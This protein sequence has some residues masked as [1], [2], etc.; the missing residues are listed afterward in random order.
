MEDILRIWLACQGDMKAVEF[1][2]LLET[3]GSAGK[4]VEGFQSYLSKG[5]DDEGDDEIFKGLRQKLSSAMD[6]RINDKLLIDFRNS[7]EKHGIKAITILNSDYPELL[8]EIQEPPPVLFIKGQW[9]LLGNTDAEGRIADSL[10]TDKDVL[11]V[12]MVG[13]RNGSEYGIKAANYLAEGLVKKGAIIVSGMALGIDS[14]AHEGALAAGGKTIAVLGSGLLNIYPSS[15][16]NMFEKIIRSGAVI[17]EFPPDMKAKPYNFP[18]RNRII[19]GI[20][21]GVV[22]V[23]ADMKSGSLI[24]VDYALAQG[25][26]VFAVPGNINSKSSRGSNFLIKQGAK[27]VLKPE[28]IL[29]EYG[30]TEE[31]GRWG[32]EI[33][34]NISNELKSICQKLET[35]PLSIDELSILLNRS[36]S[37]L[38]NSMVELELMGIV[39]KQRGRY[40]FNSFS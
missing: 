15:N 21:K 27:I 26:D 19:S 34:K 35:K 38:L 7:Y 12:A 33:S 9:P 17:S 22:V 18:R 6:T 4:A 30:I 24:T 40:V 23:E 5:K 8:R 13:S 28:D 16:R 32:G 31:D 39:Y 25:R 37:E 36:A 10:L 29:E 1:S 3:F 20:S 14:A 11:T 2:Y